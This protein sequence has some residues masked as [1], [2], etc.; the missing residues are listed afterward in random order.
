MKAMLDAMPGAVAEPMTAAR[1]SRPL[2]L[3]YKIMGKMFAILSFRAEQFVILK[4]DS[5]RTDLLR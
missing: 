1:G 5:F 4:C 3:V 2:V